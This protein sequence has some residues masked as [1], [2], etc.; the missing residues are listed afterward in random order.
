MAKKSVKKP[1]PVS[2]GNENVHIIGQFP[3]DHW[4]QMFGKMT[5]HEIVTEINLRHLPPGYQFLC[6]KQKR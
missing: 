6:I 2:D 4:F 1:K 3:T 5:P